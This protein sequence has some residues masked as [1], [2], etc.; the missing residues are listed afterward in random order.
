MEKTNE[1]TDRPYRSR[2]AE[3]AEQA[4]EFIRPWSTAP[5]GVLTGFRSAKFAPAGKA[6][7]ITFGIARRLDATLVIWSPSNMVVEYSDAGN[8]GSVS[9]ASL[10]EFAS[11]CEEQKWTV[12]GKGRRERPAEIRDRPAGERFVFEVEHFGDASAGRMPFSETVTVE[13]KYSRFGY[14]DRA[15]FI[16]DWSDWL[17]AFY[18]TERVKLAGPASEASNDK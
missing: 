15:R 3:I 14:T 12:A 9:F 7:T 18:D 13:L 6:R 2:R 17:S 4:V 5:Y 10:E 8:Y 1:K 11:F 16:A